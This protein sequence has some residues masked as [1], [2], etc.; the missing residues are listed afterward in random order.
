M[1]EK[2]VPKPKPEEKPQPVQPQQQLTHIDAKMAEKTQ[3]QQQGG[4][5]Q[6]LEAKQLWYGQVLALL[7]RA[8]GLAAQ[9]T[10]EPGRSTSEPAGRLRHCAE[11]RPALV[12]RFFPFL[13][14]IGV[15]YDTPARL[16][17]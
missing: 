12:H 8:L 15:V 5:E 6:A 4:S 3:A 1:A 9:P 11:Q 16:D 2:F 10:E 13:G 7:Q 14:R 17:V